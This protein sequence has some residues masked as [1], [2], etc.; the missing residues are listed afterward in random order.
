M[1]T[2]K[3]LWKKLTPCW[4]WPIESFKT[5]SSLFLMICPFLFV[6]DSQRNGKLRLTG[7]LPRRQ[8]FKAKGGRKG[9]KTV[10]CLAKI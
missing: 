4:Y 6:S 9:D 2:G 5:F 1:R 8:N 10:I 7:L 3:Q